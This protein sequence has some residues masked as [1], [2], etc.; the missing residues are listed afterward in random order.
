MQNGFIERFN[1]TFR[2]DILD[3][4]IF[5]SIQQFN[6]IAEKWREDYNSTHPHGSL[7]GK[8]P[9][10]YGKRRENLK[11]VPPLKQRYLNYRLSKE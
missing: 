10:E 6:V 7:D 9:K 11:G 2:E 4:Y 3:A 8:S 5:R 1:R